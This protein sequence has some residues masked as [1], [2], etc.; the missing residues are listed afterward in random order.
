MRYRL[1]LDATNANNI[2]SGT[3][4]S[5]RLPIRRGCAPTRGF[6]LPL[7]RNRRHPDWSGHRAAQGHVWIGKRPF[8][9]RPRF[10]RLASPI[11]K[12]IKSKKP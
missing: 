2:S 8:V 4:N 9:Q 1:T 7:A 5:A 11:A 6:R 12:Q 10:E 3:L